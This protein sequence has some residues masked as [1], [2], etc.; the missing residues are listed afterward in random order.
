[1]PL[2]GMRF[3]VVRDILQCR[4][5]RS[6]R[7]FR[8]RATYARLAVIAMGEAAGP[9]RYCLSSSRI[10]PHGC[11]ACTCTATGQREAEYRITAFS[12]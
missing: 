5:P 4:P 3:C 9:P 11:G 7:V 2:G 10:T 12:W 8:K 6:I 1:M